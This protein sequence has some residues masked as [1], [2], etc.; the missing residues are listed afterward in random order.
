MFN[1][2]TVVGVSS[3]IYGGSFPDKFVPSYSWGGSEGMVTYQFDKA[4]ETANRMMGRR[5]KKLSDAETNVLKHIFDAAVQD[6]P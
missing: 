3:N 6:R 5:G 2:G 4:M 1:T